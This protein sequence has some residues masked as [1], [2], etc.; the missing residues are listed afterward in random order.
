MSLYVVATPIGQPEEISQ[1]AIKILETAEV[2]I[3]EEAKVARAI[4]KSIGLKA[5]DV[6]ELNEHSEKD[7]LE[8]L[9]ALCKT[10]TV[11]LISD[12]GTPGFCDP[13]SDL[14]QLC[15]K[16]GIPVRSVPGPSSLMAFLSVCG[17][18]L[19]SFLFQGFLPRDRAERQRALGQIE[20]SSHPVILMDTPYRLK[21]LLEDI[22]FKL[23]KHPL[24]L[25]LNLGM[26]E[27]Q[28][29]EGKA[30]EILAKIEIEKAEFIL[31]VRQAPKK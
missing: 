2:I 22:S 8:H 6:E 24:V 13:G 28:V 10:K 17:H 1:Q 23:P 26:E 4:L 14:V 15:R 30:T 29:M 31:L 12:C 20:K 16:N 7:D 3:G 9:L 27:E 5:R 25:G 18:R 19:N 21:A 11:A